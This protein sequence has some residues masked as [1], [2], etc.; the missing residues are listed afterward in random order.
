VFGK[1]LAI[2]PTKIIF[3]LVLKSAQ[4]LSGSQI[5]NNIKTQLGEEWKPTP[6]A[7]YKIL[8]SL[9]DDGYILETTGSENIK[10][11]RIRKYSITDKGTKIIP[12]VSS[13]FNKVFMFMQDCCPGC[14]DNT[15]VLKINKE[16]KEEKNS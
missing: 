5:V 10:D 4:S 8:S 7:T 11:Q 6:G 3:L 1:K 12:E 16:K 14:C 13:R 15:I 9:E 2:S